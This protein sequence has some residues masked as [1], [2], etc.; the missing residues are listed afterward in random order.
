MRGDYPRIHSLLVARDGILVFE[1]YFPGYERRER[2]SSI[3][4]LRW[5]Y[6]EWVEYDAEVPHQLASVTKSVVSLLIGIAIDQ[7]YLPDRND[8]VARYFPELSAEL[9]GKKSEITIH[10]LL[11]HQTGW[12]TGSDRFQSH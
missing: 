12:E 7:G 9:I 1:E 10:H 2:S 5:P 4:L 3:A 11:T 6:Y 8:Q